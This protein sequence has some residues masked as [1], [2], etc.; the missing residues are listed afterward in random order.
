MWGFSHWLTLE[1]TLPTLV[2]HFII[3]TSMEFQ[4][5]GFTTLDTSDN[6]VRFRTRVFFSFHR[7]VYPIEIT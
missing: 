3:P 2:I 1:S 6:R 5:V 4:L 7:G